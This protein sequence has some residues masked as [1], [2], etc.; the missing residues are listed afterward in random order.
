MK[1]SLSCRIAEGFLSKEE[2]IMTLP[3]LCELAA[4]SGYEGLCMRASQIGVQSPPAAIAEAAAVIRDHGLEVTMISGDFDIV[5]NNDRG[6]NCLREITPYLDLAEA[7][8][9]RLIRVC[10]KKS[11]DF[12]HLRSAAAEAAERDLRLLHQCHVQSLFELV[13][14]IETHFQTLADVPNFGLIFEA[15]NLEQCRQDYGPETVARLAPWIQ[16]VYLQNQRLDPN[17]AVTLETWNHGPATFDIIDVHEPGGIDFARV[18]EGLRQIDYRGPI[19]VHQSAPEDGSSP[20]VSAKRTAEFLRGLSKRAS[21]SSAV[22]Q[23]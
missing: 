8:G 17:G 14:D 23:S 10:I 2:A 12:D 19:T 15:A 11:D 18:F 3:E 6:P 9:A 22:Q 4:D 5:Y 16:N 7:L 1:L 20:A 13:D 21:A